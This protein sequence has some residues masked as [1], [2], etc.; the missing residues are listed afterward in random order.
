MVGVPPGSPG[1]R[2]LSGIV[3]YRLSR[4][5]FDQILNKLVL[6]K[7]AYKQV[8]FAVNTVVRTMDFS[9]VKQQAVRVAELFSRKQAT[10]ELSD[11]SDELITLILKHLD[12]KE[13]IAAHTV[14]RRFYRLLS[15]PD[16]FLK[17]YGNASIT[18]PEKDS[19][20]SNV[21]LTR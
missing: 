18:I 6:Y 19:S 20:L 3:N 8:S 7:L 4:S 11:L 17:V 1:L 13:Q 21:A 10:V 15:R 9:F 16:P 2:S 5:F 12:F 14:S